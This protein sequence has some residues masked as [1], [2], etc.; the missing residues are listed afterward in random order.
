MG[1]QIVNT[2][3]ISISANKLRTSNNSINSAFN[4][5]QNKV[6]QISSWK[7]AAGTAAQTTA[8]NILKIS[9][10]RSKVLQNYVSFL[11]KQVNPS[12]IDTETVNTKLADK[13]K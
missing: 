13:F 12:Y 11:E 3:R 5:L 9:N 1:T 4:T 6:K 8:Q 2:D 7:G 10:E